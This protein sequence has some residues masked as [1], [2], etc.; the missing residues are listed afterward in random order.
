MDKYLNTFKV[1]TPFYD[2]A[3]Q[4]ALILGTS[5]SFTVDK[6]DRIFLTVLGSRTE[7]EDLSNVLHSLNWV[8]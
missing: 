3:V 1:F 5:V 7:L 6:G 4:I 2:R 8:S